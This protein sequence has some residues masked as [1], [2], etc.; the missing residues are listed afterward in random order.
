MNSIRR[1]LLQGLLIGIALSSAVI[2]VL[3][4]RHVRIEMDELYNAHL[5]QLASMLVAE[6][7]GSCL[8][9]AEAAGRLPAQSP[10]DWSEEN[11]LIQIW[12]KR[13]TLLRAD[14]PVAGVSAAT[15]LLQSAPGLHVRRLAGAS[16]RVFRADGEQLTVQ[17]AQPEAAR[18]GA[19]AETSL[20]ILLPLLLQIPLMSVLAWGAVRRGLFPLDRL[21]QA[22]AQRQP[23]ALT[24][25]NTSAL[26]SELQPLVHTLN[27][28]LARLDLALQQ[29]R[30][31]IADAAHELRTPIAALQLQLDLLDRAQTPSERLQASRE[32][33]CGVER[34]THLLRQL[35]QIARSE[36]PQEAE[37]VRSIALQAC[38]T[39][40]IER[41]LPAA[42]AR[43]IDLG[44]T[45][46]E[47]VAIRCTPTE[48]DTVL[49]N[50]LGNAIRYTPVGG[51]VDLA[52]YQEG[53]QA[54]VEVMDT[55]IGIPE[56]ERQR[57]FDR[58]Y[59]GLDGSASAAPIE[60]S[61]L[62]LAIIKTICDRYGVVIAV[63]SG[64]DG[65]GTRFRLSW[66]V[67]EALQD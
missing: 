49:D 34:A 44:V 64:E 36:T 6:L 15:V 14:V 9:E 26:P 39:D 8:N 52:I 58:F 42:R 43:D 27:A 3:V 46:L 23:Y 32:L 59:R 24:P 5:Q 38:G 21:K 12:D 40:A 16:W 60:G 13:G 18:R 31:F 7:D 28:L 2:G 20:R 56:A 53:K 17:V 10:S 35:L 4:Y 45:R 55:G 63:D 67:G 25:L 37:A 19:I 54:I 30:H 51:R 1:K 65:V 66:P 48:I 41:H 11:Y 29:Q 22:I 61:G 57:I 62:G 50:L 33:R 47:P